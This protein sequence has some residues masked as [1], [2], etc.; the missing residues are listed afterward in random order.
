MKHKES[1]RNKKSKQGW[2]LI[3]AG[4]RGARETGGGAV[5][6]DEEDLMGTKKH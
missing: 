4:E 5:G 6:T 3:G 1:G 2:C